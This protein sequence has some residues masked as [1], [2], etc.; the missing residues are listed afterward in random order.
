ME[1]LLSYSWPGNV[2]ELQNVLQRAVVLE[3]SDLISLASLPDT[4]TGGLPS[5]SLSLAELEGES[6]ADALKSVKARYEKVLI[7]EALDKTEGN[8]TRASKLL[9]ISRVNLHQKINEYNIERLSNDV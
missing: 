3:R 2:R 8:K 7:Q 9:K 1:R 4:I 5:T 6:L